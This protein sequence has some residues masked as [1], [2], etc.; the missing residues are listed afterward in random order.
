M[1][2]KWEAVTKISVRKYRNNNFGGE[3]HSSVTLICDLINWDSVAV[4][5]DYNQMSDVRRNEHPSTTNQ[6]V[7]N[8]ISYI[9]QYDNRRLLIVIH[10]LT[11]DHDLSAWKSTKLVIYYQLESCTKITDFSVNL[12]YIVTSTYFI[13]S[14]TLPTRISNPLPARPA[15]R[16]PSFGYPGEKCF[17][18][19][20]SKWT[21]YRSRM[22]A[23]WIR[24]FIKII[25]QKT[26]LYF[27]LL[28]Y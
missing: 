5:L 18:G 24:Y 12:S 2:G 8:S 1:K 10:R 25:R 17:G 26:R 6:L 15:V 28:F 27:K 9:V 21:I 20:I 23:F 11:A 13:Q 3:F 22:V 19:L 14:P 16:A 4:V 7:Q